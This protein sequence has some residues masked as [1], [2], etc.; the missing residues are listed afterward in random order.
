MT[1]IKDVDLQSQ[2]DALRADVQRLRDQLTTGVGLPSP[3]AAGEV[4][5]TD[6]ILPYWGALPAPSINWGSIGGTL[7]AQSDLNSA[8]NGKGGLLSANTWTAN[9]TFSTTDHTDFS[10]TGT[11]VTVGGTYS[12]T[13]AQNGV[14]S[15][16]ADGSSA[17]GSQFAAIAASGIAKR[18]AYAFF[19]TFNYAPDQNPR[20]AAHLLAGFTG[21]WGTEYLDICVGKGGGS[22]DSG[23][24]TDVVIHVTH[25]GAEITGNFSLTGTLTLPGTT[26]QYVRGDGSL[27]TFAGSGVTSVAA[28]NGM[29]FSTI[30]GTGTVTMGTPSSCSNATSNLAS[31]TTHTHA[32]TGFM[33]TSGGTFTG[34]ITAPGVTDSSDARFKRYVRDFD[35]GAAL[36][37]HL[38]PR[39]FLNELTNKQEFGFIAQELRDILPEVVS[40][41]DNGDLAVAYARIVTPLVAAVQDMQEQLKLLTRRVKDLE[42]G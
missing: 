36:V 14:V 39:R 6:A 16:S 32:I 4:L 11:R 28:G 38:R 18:A 22:N 19:P 2:I 5:Y 15:I 30:T 42:N 8:L 20:A 29:S 17:W 24:L 12:N 35:G 9:N 40:T 23:S 10:G 26:S 37:R 13:S 7:S 3:G 25:A 41:D 27:A 1:L 31:G 34:A 33:P 21:T